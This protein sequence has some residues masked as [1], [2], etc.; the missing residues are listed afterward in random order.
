MEV[1]ILKVMKSNKFI[2]SVIGGILI[3]ISTSI[4]LLFKGRITGMSGILFNLV[5]LSDFYWR[6]I[7]VLGM[8]WV[9]SGLKVF[10]G[11]KL[12]LFDDPVKSLDDLSL[13]GYLVTGFLVG[14][15]TKLSNGCTSGHGVCGLPRF[16][17]RSIVS[18]LIFC[19]F[20]IL[21]ATLNSRFKIVYNLENFFNLKKF[22]FV[23][24][25]QKIQDDNVCNLDTKKIIE[26]EPDRNMCLVTILKDTRNLFF[27]DNFQIKVFYISSAIII[28]T[29][30]YDTFYI[31][32]TFDFE[33]SIISSIL[34]AAGLI[35]SGMTKR[36]KVLG[37]LTWDKNFD[38]SLIFVLCSAVGLNSIFFNLVFNLD[39][40][41]IFADKMHIPTKINLDYKLIGGSAIFGVGW[42][43]CGVCPGPAIVT[44]L[45]YFPNIIC[46]L[47]LFFVGQLCGEKISIYY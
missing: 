7:F 8:I 25:K 42:G 13:V 20:G 1:T 38:P 34:F 26:L 18:V 10:Y 32:K 40:K 45:L 22:N 28:L 5:K 33:I 29:Y 43:I 15:G 12:N 36:S 37:F 27:S 41:P 23:T 9:S 44:S 3:S 14:L 30:L 35:V 39:Q 21:T 6:Y 2:P 47:V 24:Q 17:I 11:N 4:N 19:F 46:F 31:K 16:S